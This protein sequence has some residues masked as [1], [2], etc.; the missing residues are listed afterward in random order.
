[1]LNKQNRAC[2]TTRH[3]RMLFYCLA[4]HRKC[5]VE[6]I[7]ATRSRM[8]GVQTVPDSLLEIPQPRTNEKKQNDRKGVDTTVIVRVRT[9]AVDNP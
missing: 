1:M 9:K 2:Q 6:C 3:L 8:D 5:R 4:F 7:P